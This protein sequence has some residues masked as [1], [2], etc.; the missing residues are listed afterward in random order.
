MRQRE[1]GRHRGAAI[2][3]LRRQLVAALVGHLGGA[4]PQP[5]FAGV[6][7]WQV[8]GALSAARRWGPNGPD[9]IQ[10]TEIAAWAAL[11]GIVLPPRH[12]GILEAMD[13]AWLD[14]AR[15]GEAGQVAGV[16]TGAVFDAAFG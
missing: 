11:H 1:A 12:L 7:L 14:H 9:P 6:G 8:F 3:R 5:P 13:A 15:Q 10:P 4:R 16:M 2:A